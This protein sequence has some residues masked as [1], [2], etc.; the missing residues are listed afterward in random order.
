MVEYQ[1]AVAAINK[2]LPVGW[3]EQQP[4]ISHSSGVWEVRPRCWPVWFLVKVLFLEYRWL[5]SFSVFT[6]LREKVRLFLLSFLP[7]P[8]IK[9][10]PT[11]VTPSKCNY[12][13]KALSPNTIT[14]EVKDSTYEFVEGVWGVHNSVDSR[15]QCHKD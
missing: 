5:L 9:S 8:I 6:W 4:F 15:Q 2:M 7:L 12:Y 3:L 14:L 13:P 11:L 10:C 1:S